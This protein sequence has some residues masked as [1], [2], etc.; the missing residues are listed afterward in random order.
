MPFTDLI[1]FDVVENT[2][3]TVGE[4]GGVTLRNNWF[5][6]I[7]IDIHAI[8]VI[9]NE[10]NLSENNFILLKRTSIRPLSPIYCK[11]RES[12]EDD[13]YSLNH[14]QGKLFCVYSLQSFPF[15]TQRAG[16]FVCFARPIV[17]AKS[18][19]FSPVAV[20]FL[21]CLKKD[22]KAI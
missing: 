6:G 15:S 17:I 10:G 9:E 5:E 8:C 12:P 20:A 7:I 18:A 22:E 4:K 1:R 16:L 13:S 3:I 21:R 19:F 2:A 14:F 11:K